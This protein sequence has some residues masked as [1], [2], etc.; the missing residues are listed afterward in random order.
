MPR[1]YTLQ[2]LAERAGAEVITE[3]NVEAF[4]EALD[5]LNFDDSPVYGP[6]RVGDRLRIRKSR[7]P[8]NVGA[9]VTVVAEQFGSEENVLVAQ[10]DSG[11]KIAWNEDDLRANY[12]EFAV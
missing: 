4:Y 11:R 2:Q 12:V 3:D 10:F 6:F 7:K 8:Q 1:T 5:G 9:I